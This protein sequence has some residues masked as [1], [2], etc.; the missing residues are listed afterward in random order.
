MP[1]IVETGAGVIGANSFATLVQAR[2]FAA[3]RGIALPVDG[4]GDTAVTAFLVKATDYLK[5]LSYRDTAIYTDGNYL[6]FPRKAAY[7]VT[8]TTPTIPQGI[9]D[10]TCQLVIEQFNG[11]ELNAT[12]TGSGIRME[13]IG[14][15]TTEY[16]TPTGAGNAPK[17]SMPTVAAYLRPYLASLGIRVGRA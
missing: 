1:L 11:V 2:E 15:I 9:L 16:A 17:A 8:P 7:S 6:P 5:V 3:L 13:K 14:P 10:A 4:V 12:S